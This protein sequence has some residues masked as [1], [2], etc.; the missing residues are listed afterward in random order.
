MDAPSADQ[1]KR[2]KEQH[3][4]RALHLIELKNPGDDEIYYVVMKGPTDD[5]YKLFVDDTLGAGEK[6]KTNTEK[7]NLLKD[8]GEKAVLRQAVWPSRD[9]VKALL[10]IHPAFVDK[11]ADEIPKHAGTS[12]EVRSKKL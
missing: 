3:A 7:N 2:L 5:E 8:I 9:E 6:A 1:I 4:D 10:F 11:L 12:A